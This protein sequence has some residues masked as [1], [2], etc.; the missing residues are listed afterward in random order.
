MVNATLRRAAL[1]QDLEPRAATTLSKRL[2]R[3]AFPRWHTIFRQGEPGDRLF[4][5]LSGKVKITRHAPGSGTAL[6]ALLGPADMFGELSLLDPGPRSSG[7][8]T[9]TAVRAMSM[10][11]SAFRDLI[12]TEP[13]IAEQLLRVMARRLRGITSELCE[14]NTSDVATRVGERLLDFG[15][16]FGTTD[17]DSIRITLDLTREELAQ[18]SGT[19]RITVNRVLTDFADRGW[20]RFDG[21]TLVL[22]DPE[23]LAPPI[24]PSGAPD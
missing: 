12:A 5:I 3:I 7:A 11:R 4:I 19:S 15:R 21:S 1:L 24:Q 10:D 8:L 13:Q 17:G 6:L 14:F 22:I 20:I 16:R 2:R 9:L 18:L 23:A